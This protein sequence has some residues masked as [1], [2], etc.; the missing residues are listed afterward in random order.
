MPG[1]SSGSWRT[2]V[3][4]VGDGGLELLAD[5]VR[6]VDEPDDA[7]RRA[8]RRRHQALGLLEVADARALLG[9]RDLRDDERLAEALVEALR[10]VPGQLDV[11]ALVVPDRNDV[12]LVE[13]D[14]ARHQHRVGEQPGRDEVLLGSAVLELG[15]PAKLAEARDRAQQPRGLG[16]GRDVALGED[17]RAVGVEPGREQHRSEVERRLVQLLRLERRRDRVQVDDAEE[18]LALL[19]RGRVLAEAAAVVAE[20]LR[21]RSSDTGKDAHSTSQYRNYPLELSWRRTD[22]PNC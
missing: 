7:L 14:V 8:A 9:D 1:F 12:G 2:S 3:P 11:L 10:D 17:R 16:V 13:Q 15:H 19:L 21:P 18:R 20:G 22:H 5:D 4:G 6:W